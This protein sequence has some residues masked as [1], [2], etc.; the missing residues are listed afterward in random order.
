MSREELKKAI[1]EMRCELHALLTMLDVERQE[2]LALIAA[3][4]AVDKKEQPE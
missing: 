3:V 2:I 4:D 1:Q